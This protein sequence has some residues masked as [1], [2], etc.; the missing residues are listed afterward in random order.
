MKRFVVSLL[1]LLVMGSLLAGVSEGGGYSKVVIKKMKPIVKVVKP[2]KVVPIVKPAIDR[3][4]GPVP[5][6]MKVDNGLCGWNVKTIT[7]L[8]IV[9]GMTGVNV[10]VLLPDYFGIG[11]WGNAIG[12]PSQ[13]LTYKVGLGYVDGNDTNGNAWKAVPIF[14]DGI[15]SLPKTFG[16]DTFVGGGL[17]YVAYRTGQTSGSIGGQTY[18]GVQNDFGF[19]GKTTATVGYSI[20][21]TGASENPYSS[22]GLLLLVGQNITL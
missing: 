10:G 17:N 18:L 11:T 15:I 6:P 3:P 7:E 13:P 2:A 8:G 5:I 19:G 9:A 1:A 4:I 21:R 22:K 14:A 16:L 12:I 20:V